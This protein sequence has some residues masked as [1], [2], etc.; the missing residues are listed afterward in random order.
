MFAVV[1]G[2]TLFAVGV[3][4]MSED[5]RKSQFWR[6]GVVLFGVFLSGLTW[7]Q[8]SRQEEHEKSER[9][10][11]IEDTASKTAAKVSVVVGEQYK[12]WTEEVVAQ[13]QPVKDGNRALA[14]LVLP[15]NKRERLKKDALVLASNLSQLLL[16]R[17]IHAPVCDPATASNCY[18]V[19]GLYS[20][21]TTAEAARLG[22]FDRITKICGELKANGLV[23]VEPTKPGAIHSPPKLGAQAQELREL[24]AK[25]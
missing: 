7:W 12:T 4:V 20:S 18:S 15:L 11:A 17:R 19:Q 6:C 25:L 13:I 8:I 2:P 23:C 9:K 3:E 24:A 10:N 21:G 14:D 1:I 16:D 22:Y 5:A